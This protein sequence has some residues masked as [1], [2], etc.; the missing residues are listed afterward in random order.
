MAPEEVAGI[1]FD[2]TCSLVVLDSSGYPLPVNDEGVA[3][4]GRLVAV[5]EVEPELVP[6][7]HEPVVM[8]QGAERPKIGLPVGRPVAG[9]V[10]PTHQ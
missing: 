3:D 5:D 2:A 9:Y 6:A 4:R 7:S 10:G 8:V 1:S